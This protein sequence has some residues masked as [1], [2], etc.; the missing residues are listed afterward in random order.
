MRASV[1]QQ[2]RNASQ[3]RQPKTT[4]TASVDSR[5]R[6]SSINVP[7]VDMRSAAASADVD[8]DNFTDRR[9]I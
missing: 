1:S 7:L 4:G 6:S 9:R 3:T 8:V 5:L 2:P